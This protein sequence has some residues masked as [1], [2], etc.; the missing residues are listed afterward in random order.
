MAPVL[1]YWDIRGL[2]T[3]IRL[4][5]EQAGV[6]YEEKLYKCGPP[7]EFNRSEW[8]DEKFNLGLD[9]PNLPYY[10][11]GDFELTQSHVI[12]RYLAKKHNLTGRTDNEQ[13]LVDKVATQVYD[14]H[15]EYARVVYNPD[16]LK[17]RDDYIKGMPA[18]LKL[19]SECLGKKQFVAGD[20]V[21]YADFVL[22]EYLE[23]QLYF[24]PNVL[25]EFP[26]LEKY[27]FNITKLESVE[28]YFNSARAI[29]FPF[30]GAP[31]LFGGAYSEQILKS[32]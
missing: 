1:G 7:P 6:Q 8:L 4:L 9:F 10:K 21:T 16:Y 31:A 22:F 28:K 11:D 27:H 25:K 18:K 13:A 23:G 19:L 3:P 2:A 17:L 29:K 26:S 20:Y 14:Y 32:K 12:L 30:N 15:M 5:L 24:N